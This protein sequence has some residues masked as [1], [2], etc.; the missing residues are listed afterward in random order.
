M[1]I[2]FLVK[3]LTGSP[4]IP[5]FKVDRLCPKCR[6]PRRNAQVEEAI[7]FC[8]RLLP[9]TRTISQYLNRLRKIHPRRS[10]TPPGSSDLFIPALPLFTKGG[11]NKPS[12][13]SDALVLLGEEGEEAKLVL[14]ASDG[15]RLLGEE[16]RALREQRD[17]LIEIFPDDGSIYTWSESFRAL[18]VQHCE[19]V[20]V[21]WLEMVDYVE[22]ML[23]AQL[24]AAIGK[25]VKPAE[26]VG[27]LGKKTSRQLSEISKA[28][29]HSAK[30]SYMRFHYRK[31]FREA[32]QPCPCR[33]LQAPCCTPQTK[34]TT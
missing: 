17:N 30:A 33:P 9:W 5:V 34:E 20:L 3:Q 2:T 16:F 19:H 24:V 28:F 25:E 27:G 1:N 11:S 8:S 22:H 4:P 14:S 15:N 13:S 21:Q 12:T 10:S 18:I 32:Y 7:N 26:F 31:L 23:R 6:T 29:G